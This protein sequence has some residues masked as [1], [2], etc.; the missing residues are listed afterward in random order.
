MSDADTGSQAVA[1]EPFSPALVD[2]DPADATHTHAVPECEELTGDPQPLSKATADEH[3]LVPC[4]S[5]HEVEW[6]V[7][8]TA[9][10]DVYHSEACLEWPPVESR[11]WIPRGGTWAAGGSY[12]RRCSGEYDPDAI[13]GNASACPVCGSDDIA[14]LADHIM[15]TH[16]DGG[17]GR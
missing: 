12:C 3:R 1:G 6:V 17:D 9:E 11:V 14:N 7:S 4:R 16:G 13:P 5:C 8:G 2:G 10:T 15:R